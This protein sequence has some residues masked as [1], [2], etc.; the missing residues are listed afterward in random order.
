MTQCQ[1]E[2]RKSSINVEIS[3]LSYRNVNPCV[4][5][6]ISINPRNT[7]IVIKKYK[8]LCNICRNINFVIEKYKSSCN[9]EI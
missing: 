4:P 2:N 1:N 7:N 5:K 6:N 8:L 3:I 9:T